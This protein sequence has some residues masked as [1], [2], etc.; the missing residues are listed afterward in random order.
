MS[1][2]R[3][4]FR[5]VN[6]PGRG[7]PVYPK[8]TVPLTHVSRLRWQP[9]HPEAVEKIAVAGKLNVVMGDKGLADKIVNLI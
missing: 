9:S 2:R 5:R 1:L 4:S 3:G 6:S 8:Q 7:S